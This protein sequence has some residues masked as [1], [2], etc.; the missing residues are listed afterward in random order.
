M[1]RISDQA[2]IAAWNRSGSP[3]GTARI[4]DLSLR[5]VYTRRAQLVSKGIPLYTDTPKRTEYST[6]ASAYKPRQLDTIKDGYLIVFSDAHYWPNK[7]SIAHEALVI[8]TKQLKPQVLIAN[9]D[10]FDGYNISRHEPMGWVKGPKVIEE[11]D[12]VKKRLGE[13]ERASPKSRRYLTAGN[14]D[15]RFDRRLATEI[16]QFEDVPGMKLQDHL[17]NWP[18][19]Y[20]VLLNQDIDPVF[21]LH[22][23]RGGWSAPRNNAVASGCTVITGHLHAQKAIPVTTLLKD[24]EGIDAG[25]LAE[26]DG[27]Q[28]SYTMDRPTD[29]RSGFAVMRFDKNGYRF[30]VEFAR[31][32]YFKNT[33][34][35]V[36]RGEV[37]IERPR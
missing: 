32:Q 25:M 14:H 23:I 36:F 13:L 26:T 4:L 19:S 15:T 21:V 11:L 27:D 12:E 31:T 2:F 37:I 3:S 33:K 9:G 28:F 10:V 6:G 7:T 5:C 24:W 18:M 20:T 1:K 17:Q 29:W 30:P 34:R 35:V 8:L 16:S 22:N